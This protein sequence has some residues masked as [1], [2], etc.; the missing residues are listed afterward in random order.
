MQEQQSVKLLFFWAA[1][2][3]SGVLLFLRGRTW[4]RAVRVGLPLRGTTPLLPPPPTATSLLPP[5]PRPPTTTPG[6]PTTSLTSTK[7]RPSSWSGMW[8]EAGHVI[9]VLRNISSPTGWILSTNWLPS[10][11]DLKGYSGHFWS[12]AVSDVFNSYNL[13]YCEES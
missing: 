5:S 4:W 2:M 7:W 3:K 10:G 6:P 13:I 9:S 11:P 8:T 12:D 1:L